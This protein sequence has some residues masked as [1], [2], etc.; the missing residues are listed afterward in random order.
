MRAN[1]SVHQTDD[2]IGCAF[3]APQ[4]SCANGLPSTCGIFAWLAAQAA[5]E[6]AGEG[7]KEITP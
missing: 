7:Q 2:T 5:A 3:R 1:V 4:F 6:E